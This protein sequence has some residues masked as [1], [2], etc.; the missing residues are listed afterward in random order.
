MAT[1]RV[2]EKMQCSIRFVSVNYILV[3]CT[4]C[5]FWQKSYVIVFCKGSHVFQLFAL[6]TPYLG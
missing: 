3:Q 2:Q 4:W 1:T 6:L 5:T